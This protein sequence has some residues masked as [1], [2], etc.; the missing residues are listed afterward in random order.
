MEPEVDLLADFYRLGSALALGLLV[1]LQREYAWRRKSGERGGEF[2]GART[3]AVLALLGYSAAAVAELSASPWVLAA[4]VVTLG[5]IIAVGYAH[6]ARG[7]QLGVTSEVAAL[8]TLLAGTLCFYGKLELAAAL[9]VTMTVMLAIKPHTVAIASRLTAEDVRAT[10][11]FAVLTLVILPLLPRTGFA[12]PPFD[13]LVPYKVWLMVVFISG[14]SFAGYVMIKLVGSRKGVALTG[15]LGGLASSTAVTL[16]F[17]QRSRDTSA[18]AR[19]F[20]LAILLSWT[21]MFLRVLV[22]VA[23]LNLALLPKVAVPMLAAAMVSLGYCA[24]LYVAQRDDSRVEEDSFT[25]P[26]E[27]WPALTFGAIYMVILLAANVARIHFGET[28]LYASS[29]VSGLADVDAITLSMA[30]LSKIPDGLDH[31]IAARAIILAAASNTLVK[32]CIVLV[33]GAPALSRVALPGLAIILGTAVG[34]A[35]LQ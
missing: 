9:A 6:S 34:V 3:F 33:A 26:F 21:I 35:F 28:G 14:I 12:P 29:I 24:Y 8:V 18:L 2:A 27:L 16:S 11:T 5:G 10:L 17:A 19:P 25:N 30:E 31:D 23:V 32:G 7:G 15:I 13:V 22:E 1:G 20:A 4:V